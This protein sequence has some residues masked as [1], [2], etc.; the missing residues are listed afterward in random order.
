MFNFRAWRSGGRSTELSTSTELEEKGKTS[1]LYF[2]LLMQNPCCT[3]IFIRGNLNLWLLLF[4]AD[5]IV[6]VKQDIDLVLYS[7]LIATKI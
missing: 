5:C 2:T 6:E 4:V 3:S 1:N 7:V